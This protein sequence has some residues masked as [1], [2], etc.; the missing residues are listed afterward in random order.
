RPPRA[1]GLHRH[2]RARGRRLHAPGSCLTATRGS[3]RIARAGACLVGVHVHYGTAGARPVR[4]AFT[5]TD[6]R[7]DAA[8]MRLAAA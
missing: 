5:A 3:R 1:S 6:E 4:V 8:C 7:V 2:R